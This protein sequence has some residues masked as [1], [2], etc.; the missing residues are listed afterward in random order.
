MRAAW[1]GFALGVI[2]LQRQAALPHWPEWSA[3][4]ALGGVAL[5]VAMWGLGRDGVCGSV[6]AAGALAPVS[7]VYRRWFDARLRKL[8]GW[9]AV[10]CALYAPD[11]L[12]KVAGTCLC[13]AMLIGVAS[14]W[15]YGSFPDYNF[16]ASARRVPG[17]TS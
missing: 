17:P 11:R 7:N 15:R 1:C 9:S 2:G 13:F 10:W 4:I 16:A 3:L 5:F 14:D 8:A 6:S 12:F